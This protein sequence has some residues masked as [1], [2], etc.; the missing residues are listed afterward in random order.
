MSRPARFTLQTRLPAYLGRA[1]RQAA[2][3]EAR[4]V[5]EIIRSAL[6]KAVV[7]ASGDDTRREGRS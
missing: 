3:R 1:L 7:V 2:A 4:T 5:S 6:A